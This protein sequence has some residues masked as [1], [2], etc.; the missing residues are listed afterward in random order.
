M[1]SSNPIGAIIGGVFGGLIVLLLFLLLIV[2]GMVLAVTVSRWKSDKAK[3]T[4]NDTGIHKIIDH[5]MHDLSTCL[6]YKMM[7]SLCLDYL[8]HYI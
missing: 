1:E 4:S 2:M 8:E 7:Q 5:I 6:A 3:A